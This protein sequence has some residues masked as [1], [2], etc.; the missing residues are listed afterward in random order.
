MDFIRARHHIIGIICHAQPNFIPDADQN[1][2]FSVAL[3]Q[4]RWSDD[5]LNN[6]L[7]AGDKVDSTSPISA[8]LKQDVLGFSRQDGRLSCRPES[9][10]RLASILALLPP[11]LGTNGHGSILAVLNH[12][13][14]ALAQQHPSQVPEVEE[15]QAACVEPAALA[16]TRTKPWCSH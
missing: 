5:V 2:S 12:R 6:D 8:Q 15:W 9:K 13:V 10:R 11:R 4:T 14:H 16:I 1:L 3:V 7:V